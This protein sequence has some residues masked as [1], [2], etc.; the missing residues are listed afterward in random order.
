MKIQ[1]I[2]TSRQ[3]HPHPEGGFYKETYRSQG[4]ISEG[5]LN[6][7]FRGNRAY[8]TGI[9]FL[10]TKDNFSAFHKIKQDE[11]VKKLRG[12]KGTSVVVTIKRLGSDNFDVTLIRDK[13]P[14]NSVLAAFLYDEDTGYINVNRFGEKTF[15]QKKICFPEILVVFVSRPGCTKVDFSKGTQKK[16]LQRKYNRKSYKGNAKEDF[17]KEIRKTFC[18]GDT[19]E[20]FTKEIQKQSLQRK[21]KR[22]F[23]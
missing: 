18:K 9:Y 21:C 5:S 14:I 2:I 20:N 12:P 23:Y 13:I 8:C 1:Q 19:T 16:I 6:E 22:R 10:L 15:I 17:T 7:N 11:I 3:L 4:I